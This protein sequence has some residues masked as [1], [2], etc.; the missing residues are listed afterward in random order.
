MVSNKDHFYLNKK[1]IKHLLKSS[2]FYDVFFK[3]LL[4]TNKN[5]IDI[6]IK[7]RTLV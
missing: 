6:D 5:I 1:K 3:F 4:Q 2:K 7:L